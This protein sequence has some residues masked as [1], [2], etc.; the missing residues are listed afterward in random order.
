M[1]RGPALTR[2]CSNCP[3]RRGMG[4]LR[5][6]R[7][8]QIGENMLSFDGGSFICHRTAGKT[9]AHCAGAAIFADKNGVQTQMMRIE[10]R[11]GLMGDPATF[12]D[13]D[14]I[15]DDLDE[16]VEQQESTR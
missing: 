6:A 11:L 12:A 15:V 2:P 10:Q 13:R 14:D 5:R 9:E 4:F 8:R 7:A 3:F 16:L 1:P